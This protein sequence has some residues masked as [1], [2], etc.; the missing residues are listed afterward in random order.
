M[1]ILTRGAQ[2][3]ALEF[4]STFSLLQK[5]RDRHPAKTAIVDLE[6]NKSI[7]F[8][9]LFAEANRIAHFLWDHGIRKGEIFQFH[10]KPFKRIR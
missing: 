7:T 3:Q 6:Q 8:G 1:A 9:E 4:D 2:N 10:F 5:Y